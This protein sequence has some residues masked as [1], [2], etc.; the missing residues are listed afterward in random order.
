MTSDQLSEIPSETIYALTSTQIANISPSEA[1]GL[2]SDFL[3][4]FSGGSYFDNGQG[5]DIFNEPIPGGF[6][7]WEAHPLNGLSHEHIANLPNDVFSGLTPDLYSTSTLKLLLELMPNIWVIYLEKGLKG[8]HK[9]IYPT[10]PQPLWNTYKS[11]K[12]KICRFIPFKVS[13]QN[14]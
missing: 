4:I 9:S 7:D 8:F 13:Q 1:S 11:I 10:F 14:I 3:S 2:G 5:S 6:N 12:L